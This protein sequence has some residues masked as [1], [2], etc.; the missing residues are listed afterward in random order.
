MMN[1]K[2]Q[3]RRP[4]FL[5]GSGLMALLA[6]AGSVQAAD[7][8]AAVTASVTVLD[9]ESCTITVS[10]ASHTMAMTWSRNA[11]G[12][13]THDV[14]SST[15]PVNVTLH[16]TGGKT[17][18]LN[19]LTLRTEMGSGIVP[20]PDWEGQNF[21]FKKSFGSQGGFWRF[22]PYL[23]RAQ[24]YTDEQLAKPGTGKITWNGPSKAPHNQMNFGDTA[25]IKGKQ[26]MDL[27]SMGGEVRFLTDQYVEDGGALLIDKGVNEGTFTSSA[28]DET[29]RS[30]VLG[31]GALMATAPENV[32][33]T[34]EPALAA[35]GDQ[36]T[37]T[38]TVY[39]DQA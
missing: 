22:M 37:M 19:N 11:D 34:R 32:N 13:P 18:T 16:A 5:R 2:R 21:T 26:L 7:N 33:G 8:S 12:V 4:V 35:G 39:I 3:Y 20:G 23:A 17:C 28:A 6:L 24:F 27:E 15:D 38:W 25:T 30:A 9:T 14:T 1:K 29:Y 31:F 36:V 10:S